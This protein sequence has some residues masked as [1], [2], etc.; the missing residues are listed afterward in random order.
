MKRFLLSLAFPALL[1]GGCYATADVGAAYTIETGPPPPETVVVTPRPGYIWIDGYWG[2]GGSRWAWTPGYY[3]V[4]RP[5]YAYV[6]GVWVN[7][8]GR[9]HYTPGYWR[10]STVVVPRRRPV[11]PGSVVVPSQRPGARQAWRP[12]VVQR[13]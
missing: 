6:Q 9:Y 3:V 4:D 10:N 1:L 7:H 12:A 5:G 2:W 8:G 11:G 13:S